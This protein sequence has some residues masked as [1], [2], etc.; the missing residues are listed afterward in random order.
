MKGQRE[1]K[2]NNSS[3]QYLVI[4]LSIVARLP[5]F[6]KTV[7]FAILSFIKTWTSYDAQEHKYWVCV[8]SRR[9]K[10]VQDPLFN[11]REYKKKTAK[12]EADKQPEEGF[13]IRCPSR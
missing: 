1:H 8:R 5:W 10:F 9:G 4:P 13:M 3:G 6:L 2:S 12:A 7:L 11:K